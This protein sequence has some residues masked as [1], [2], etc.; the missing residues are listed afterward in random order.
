M[1][2]INES[3]YYLSE[4]ASTH[5]DGITHKFNIHPI[6]VALLLTIVAITIIVSQISQLNYYKLSPVVAEFVA[7]DDLQN[8]CKTKGE[9]TLLEN[10]Y[11]YAK[12]DNEGNLILILSDRQIQDW[13][14]SWYALTVFQ[15]M[16]GDERPIGITTQHQPDAMGFYE[17]ADTC[18]LDISDDFKTIIESPDDN[19][20][21]YAFASPCCIFMQIIN[22]VPSDEIYVDY[23]RVDADGKV[24]EHIYWPSTT[25]TT[26]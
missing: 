13:K 12:V 11:T 26:S 10:G 3:A 21:Y 5:N 24:I 2:I 25:D 4:E 19:H 20:W 8:F 1:K 16:L 22:G 23:Y 15:R 6:L 9:G 7:G 17:N 18:G 14:N